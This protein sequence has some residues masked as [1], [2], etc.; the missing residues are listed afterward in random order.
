MGFTP[1]DYKLL[2]DAREKW[3]AEKRRKNNERRRAVGAVQ[4][5]DH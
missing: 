4:T 1:V 3:N 2:E 5:D